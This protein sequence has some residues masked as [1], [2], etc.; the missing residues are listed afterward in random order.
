VVVCEC[1]KLAKGAQR[2]GRDVCSAILCTRAALAS[3]THP[4]DSQD[5]CKVAIPFVAL[6]SATVPARDPAVAEMERGPRIR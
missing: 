1:D 6:C 2:L 4:R 3:S 5:S